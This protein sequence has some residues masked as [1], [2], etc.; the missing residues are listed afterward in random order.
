M[1]R[2]KHILLSPYFISV[3]PFL[4]IVIFVPFR[5]SRYLLKN[6]NVTILQ[7]DTYIWYSDLDDDG[8]SE[9]ISAFD[10]NNSTGLTISNYNGVID[11]WNLK[12]NFGFAAKGCLY[13]TGDKEGDGKKEIYVFTIQGDTILLHCISNLNSSSFSI[14]NRV[15]CVAGKGF[16]GPDPFIIPAE[17]DDLNGDG[18]NE[19]I[20]GIGSGFSHYPRNVY[21]YYIPEDSLV[22]SPESSYFIGNIL[23]YDIDDDGKREI[24]PYGY[25]A[26][27]V[28]PEKALYHDYSSFLMVLDNNLQFRFKP[29]EFRGKFSGLTPF[30][31]KTATGNK[32]AALFNPSSE[33]MNS[34]VYFIDSSGLISDSLQ[35][36][37]FAIDC[38]KS[39]DRTNRFDE[40]LLNVSGIGIAL[41]NSDLKQVKLVSLGIN[42]VIKQLDIDNDGSEEIL[43]PDNENG[44]LIIYR[45][46]LNNPVSVNADLSGPGG[47]FISLKTSDKSDP[48]I[49]VQSGQKVYLLKYSRNPAYPYYYAYYLAIYLS[50]LGFALL[51]R[52]I[53]K[54]QLKRKYDTEKKL[55]ELQLALVR[56]QLD[57]HFT[58]NVINSIIYSIETSNKRKAG[59]GLRRFANLYRSLL[60]SAGS[61]QSKISEELD[62]CNDYLLLEKMRFGDRFDFRITVSDDVNRDA[63]IPKLLIQIHAENAV[64]HGLSD[65]EK[66]GLLDINL[67]MAENTLRIE[68]TDNGIGR[69]ES[70]KLKKISTGKGLVIMDELY[71]IYNRYYDD[72]VSSEISDL[73]N[74]EGKP[75][76]TRVTITIQGKSEKV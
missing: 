58:L 28:T 75:A 42:P 51:I 27:N 11:Q 74:K 55:S 4:I 40:Y 7:K 68:I 50:I 8:Q 38:I 17:M 9:K 26:C 70:G 71:S 21:A 19:L 29:L 67:K 61:T 65:K 54:D 14:E 24:I 34:T 32:L 36:P 47:S 72:K 37:Y 16:N 62:F 25:A 15:I 76:G 64:K 48:V 41:L 45:K 6:E 66:G 39:T 3:I 5:F 43:V 20:F 53:Q 31:K 18:T 73:Y 52:N 69:E 59:D 63:L 60:M 56:N 49:S 46:G 35:L 13:I 44:K 12:G 1:K 23:Q 10:L 30:V 33:K 57:P 2:L 22:V